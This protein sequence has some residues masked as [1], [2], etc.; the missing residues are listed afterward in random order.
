MSHPADIMI[1][2]HYYPEKHRE[3]TEIV[4]SQNESPVAMHLPGWPGK[5][6]QGLT[7]AKSLRRGCCSARC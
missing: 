3:M 7:Q 5:M 2:L 4:M 6:E 1:K